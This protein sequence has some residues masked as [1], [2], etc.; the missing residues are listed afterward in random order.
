MRCLNYRVRHPISTCCSY[1]FISCI[2]LALSWLVYSVVVMCSPTQQAFSLVLFFSLTLYCLVLSLL[3]VYL[4]AFSLV[5]FWLFLLLALSRV[6]LSLWVVSLILMI[7][8][9]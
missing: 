1:S 8:K 4:L 2:L 9:V 6:L 3:M 5:P 7:L